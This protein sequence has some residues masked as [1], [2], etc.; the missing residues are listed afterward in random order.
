[1]W[2]MNFLYYGP[3]GSA[4]ISFRCV[5]SDSYRIFVVLFP[6]RLTFIFKYCGQAGLFSIC[7]AALYIRITLYLYMFLIY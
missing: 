4:A 6:A 3:G 5:A 2:Q 1:M 7:E